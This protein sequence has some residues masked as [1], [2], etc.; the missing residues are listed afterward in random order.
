MDGSSKQNASTCS[1]NDVLYTGPKIGTDLVKC[2]IR[3][4]CGR[5]AATSDLE[6]AFLILL[7][8]TKDRDVIS[9]FSQKIFTI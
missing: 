2:I 3:M 9:F 6:K 1:L 5:Y 4:R 7:I 8:R